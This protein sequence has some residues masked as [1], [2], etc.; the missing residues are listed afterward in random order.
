MQKGIL[1]CLSGNVY[2]YLNKR[3]YVKV[4]IQEKKLRQFVD[5]KYLINEVD[6]EQVLMVKGVGMLG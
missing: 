6:G 2:G 5:L 3:K 4:F 1:N